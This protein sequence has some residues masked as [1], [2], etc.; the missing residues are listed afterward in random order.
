MRQETFVARHEREWARLEAWLDPKA[1]KK[2]GAE[3]GSESRKP[4]RTEDFPHAYRR[5]CQQLAL[6]R[7]RAYSPQLVERLQTL[8]E[9]GHRRFYR[10]R[11]PEWHRVQRF[12][13]RDFPALVRREWRFITASA[14]LLY[15]P[16][17]V[18]VFLTRYKPELVYSLYSPDMVGQFESMYDPNQH[19][20]TIGRDSASNL[21]A[22]G[23]Y[24]MHNVSIGFQTMA[25]G[26]FAGV[27]SLFELLT[28]G[29]MIGSVAGYLTAVGYGRT[30]WPFV[31]GHSAWELS[32]IVIT[33]G[34]GLKLGWALL[35]PGRDSRGRALVAAGRSA[36]LLA[37]GAFLMLVVAAFIEAYWSSIVWLPAAV[38]YGVSA[39]MWIVVFTWLGAGGRHAA[40]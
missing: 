31:S 12:V 1:L 21:G 34:A 5:V 25:G 18:M 7:T 10:T 14:V 2:K 28:N 26:L 23:F 22:F 39:F 8:V 19:A 33:G 11:R 27:G 35:A 13:A 37:L 9:A 38:K 30:F 3:V 36:A 6:A 20:Q 15:G 16:M 24:V 32:A 17:L 29:L 4:L 40:R